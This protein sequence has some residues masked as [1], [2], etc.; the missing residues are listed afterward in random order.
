MCIDKCDTLT[1][2]PLMYNVGF[3][4]ISSLLLATLDQHPHAP[5]GRHQLLEEARR[6]RLLTLNPSTSWPELPDRSMV[7]K[8]MVHTEN[9]P[10]TFAPVSF[11]PS[12]NRKLKLYWRVKNQ[13]HVGTATPS[14]NVVQRCLLSR[15]EPQWRITIHPPARC[16][17]RKEI[18]RGTIVR[19]CYSRTCGPDTTADIPISRFWADPCLKARNIRRLGNGIRAANSQQVLF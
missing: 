16:W 10:G 15:K 11:C 9:T 7:T 18:G 17:K 1:K 4:T 14:L 19:T 12:I 13:E 5:S 2:T 6:K 8:Q 3:G